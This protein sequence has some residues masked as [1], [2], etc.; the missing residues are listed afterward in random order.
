MIC[1][2]H[3]HGS[4]QVHR[5]KDELLLAQLGRLRCGEEDD[6]RDAILELKQKCGRRLQPVEVRKASPCSVLY[7]SCTL[8][9]HRLS[10]AIGRY[11]VSEMGAG[12]RLVETELQRSKGGDRQLQGRGGL[13]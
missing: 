2:L 8:A 1:T 3:L 6:R 5:Q 10:W 9:S 11:R 4:A 12:A 7:G 13:A